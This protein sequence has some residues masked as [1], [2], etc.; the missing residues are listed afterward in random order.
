MAE[1]LSS[2][3]I[4]RQ[5]QLAEPTVSYHIERIRTPPARSPVN[6][7]VQI[8]A[9]RLQ[10]NTRQRV[11]ELLARGLSR[12]EVARSLGLSK[13]TVSYHARRL[14]LPID[15]RCAR[16]YDWP[17]VQRYYD[18]G[19]S[20]RQCLEAFGI[21]HQTWHAAKKRGAIT[22][23]PQVTPREELFVAGQPRSRANLKRRLLAERLKP[24]VCAA[25]GIEQ[26]HGRPLSMAL[27][28]IN[29][30]RL[31]NRLENLELLCP[32]CHSQTGTYSGRNGH[33]RRAPAGVAT[34]GGGA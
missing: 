16:R 7:A 27:H 4:A 26:W 9:V 8:E 29:G 32:N 24:N 2:T 12:T 17:V 19:H 30:D 20:V 23:R 33:R 5:L 1:G 31:D 15:D 14:G 25:C 28:H 22:T 18:E 34:P 10:L 13:A 11:A 3:A 6:R 21:A